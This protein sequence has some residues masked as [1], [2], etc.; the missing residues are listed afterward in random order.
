MNSFVSARPQDYQSCLSFPSLVVD[1]AVGPI[2]YAEK[3]QG[4]ALLVVHGG[5]GGYDQ[6]LAIGECFG[7]NG[8]RVIAVSRPGYLGTPLASGN[9]LQGQADAL[10]ALVDALGLA[11][12]PVVAASAGGLLPILLPVRI[13]KRS[14]P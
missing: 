10:A 2:G 6:G 13:R 3:G 11:R 7:L 12:V 4:P 1:T 5:P 14:A 8:F 9:S